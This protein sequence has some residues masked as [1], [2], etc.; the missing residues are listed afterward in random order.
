MLRNLSCIRDVVCS[1]AGNRNHSYRELL[2]GQTA[3]EPNGGAREPG[4]VCGDRHK[5]RHPGRE[6]DGS[7]GIVAAGGLHLLLDTDNPP[8]GSRLYLLSSSAGTSS[9]AYFVRC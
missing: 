8:T 9:L 2:D 6:P 1:R 4:V 7:L 5:R 3:L